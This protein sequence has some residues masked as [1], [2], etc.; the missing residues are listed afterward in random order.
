MLYPVEGLPLAFAPPE[1]LHRAQF[2]VPPAAK[3]EGIHQVS[4]SLM[5]V[6]YRYAGTIKQNFVSVPL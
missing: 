4:A 1:L 3:L 2:A 6:F 5:K